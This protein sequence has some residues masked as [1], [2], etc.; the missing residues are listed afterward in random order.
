MAGGTETEGWALAG[1]IFLGIAV[2][3]V[4]PLAVITLDRLPFLKAESKLQPLLTVSI[5]LLVLAICTATHANLFLGAFSAGITVASR[6]PEYRREFEQ[7]GEL[8]TEI[9]K[10]AAILVF[11]ALIT[12]DFLFQEIPLLGWV[13]AI[14]AILVA[15]PAAL[16]VSFVGANLPGKQRVAARWF[17][18]KGFA[19]VVY[20]LLVLESGI[21]E[22]DYVFHL[23]GLVIVLSILA[24]SSTDVVIARQFDEAE[25]YEQTT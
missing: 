17:G 18:P 10:L 23:V 3:V 16:L 11:G 14:L 21:V 12:P 15:R 8:V 25:S 1:E 4:V 19:S 2:G 5:G 22:A 20:G 24:H 9:L 6:G 7:F 13:F